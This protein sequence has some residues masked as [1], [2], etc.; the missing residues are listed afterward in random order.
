[1]S[2]HS[3]SN[4][5]SI[6]FCS[7]LIC[8][9]YIAFLQLLYCPNILSPSCYFFSLHI[10][11][12]VF[13]SQRVNCPPYIGPPRHKCSGICTA[14]QHTIRVDNLSP[15]FSDLIP[16]AC[17]INNLPGF[18]SEEHTSELQSQSNLVCRLL[19][20]KKKKKKKK[21]KKNKNKR[22]E[23]IKKTKKKKKKQMK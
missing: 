17:G 9:I 16:V 15:S 6:L 22:K 21:N 7:K 11:C 19:L 20:E 4:R 12:T 1:M 10:N 14:H 3:C 13:L 23:K 5:R 2:A 8:N 18:R